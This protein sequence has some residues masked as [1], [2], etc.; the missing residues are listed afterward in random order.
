M[1]LGFGITNDG[2]SIYTLCASRPEGKWETNPRTPD[3]F[4]GCRAGLALANGRSVP[5]NRLM[6]RSS[7]KHCSRSSFLQYTRVLI[8]S[9]GTSPSLKPRTSRP[10]YHV[11]LQPHAVTRLSIIVCCTGVDHDPERYIKLNVFIYMLHNRR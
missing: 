5:Y 7:R 3:Y 2:A 1:A 4:V 6:R 8:F 11:T 9:R 10:A